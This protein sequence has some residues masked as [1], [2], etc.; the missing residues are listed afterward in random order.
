MLVLAGCK[1]TEEQQARVASKLP[2]GCKIIDLGEY[3]D[4]DNLVVVTCNGYQTQ[5]MN[6]HWTRQCG[7]ARC[8]HSGVSANIQTRI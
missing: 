4:F 2:E 1:P 7:K 3:G 8:S 5:T 6:M